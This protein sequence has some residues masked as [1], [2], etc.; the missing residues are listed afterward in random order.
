MLLD[1]FGIKDVAKK[2]SQDL[3]KNIFTSHPESGSWAL[4]KSQSTKNWL[5]PSA[6]A[7]IQTVDPA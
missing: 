2:N 1:S 7:R 5:M 6:Q 4:L 3:Q